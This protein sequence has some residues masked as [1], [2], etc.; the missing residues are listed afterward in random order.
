MDD[1]FLMYKDLVVSMI[2][3]NNTLFFSEFENLRKI[4]IE[5][6]LNK[7]E[8][9]IDPNSTS[10]RLNLG[11]E[12]IKTKASDLSVSGSNLNIIHVVKKDSSMNI[13]QIGNNTNEV[14]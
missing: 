10:L 14:I 1:N 8:G 7:L 13:N 9:V 2:N 11:Q 6:R 12:T 3:E 4:N 5:S